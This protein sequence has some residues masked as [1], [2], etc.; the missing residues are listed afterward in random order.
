MQ[1]LTVLHSNTKASTICFMQDLLLVLL[2]FFPLFISDLF[3]P[4]KM[5]IG[6]KVVRRIR[7]AS[8]E[9]HEGLDFLLLS[10]NLHGKNQIL[11]SIPRQNP[12]KFASLIAKSDRERVVG[13]GRRILLNM[14]D[15]RHKKP[16]K[17]VP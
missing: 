2:I 13:A 4:S 16:P 8:K 6:R 14:K 5:N 3:E 11:A 15:A 1:S 17:D 9:E 12:S 10:R 7:D